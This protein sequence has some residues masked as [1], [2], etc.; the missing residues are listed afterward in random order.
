ML[1][2]V[3]EGMKERGGKNKIVVREGLGMQKDSDR[4]K[5]GKDTDMERI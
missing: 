2:T 5:W 3:K 1:G 4:H